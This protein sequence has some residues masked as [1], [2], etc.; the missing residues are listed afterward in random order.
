MMIQQVFCFTLLLFLTDH[1][2]GGKTEEWY[3]ECEAGECGH[4][5]RRGSA[6]CKDSQEQC[7]TFA[8][9]GE[10]KNNPTWMNENCQ[11]SCGLCAISSD[12]DD[13]D[14]APCKD[15]HSSCPT[16]AK[17][18]ECFS[19]PAYMARACPASCWLCVNATAL[20]ENGVNEEDIEHIDKFSQTDFGL[21]QSIPAE[22]KDGQVRD[23]VTNMGKYVQSLK[24][25]GP[26]TLCN[27]LHHDCAAWVIEKGCQ[28]DLEFMLPS[29]SLA[30]Q[31]CDIIEEYHT[32][33]RLT[34]ISKRVPF[35]PFGKLTVIWMNLFHQLNAENLLEDYLED[36]H[37]IDGEYV[38]SLDYSALWGENTDAEREKVVEILKSESAANL[39]WKNATGENYTDVASDVAPDRSGRTAICSAECRSSHPAMDAL[40]KL[41]SKN[42]LQIGD[43][44]LQPLEFVHYKRGERFAAH[45]DFRLHD[46]WKQSGNRVLTVFIALQAPKE[47]GGVGFPELDWLL[48]DNPQVLVW[49]NVLRSKGT[50]QDEALTRMKSE[51]LPVVA[52]E[53]YGVYAWLRQYPYDESSPCA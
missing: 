38:L 47:G 42:L 14:E 53:M 21:W 8:L 17:E 9:R 7:R 39:E 26:G 5:G 40:A 35:W 13:E 27:N 34:S 11:K 33:Q 12:D 31:Y 16:W 10:C 51:Q 48:I 30:C 6:N 46:R 32:C 2:V 43:E 52:G 49:P 3:Q 28:D 1:R 23:E 24:K 29:C 37:E 18:L 19:N 4:S 50:G 45:H 41:I 22:D 20:R 15:L 44:Y 36:E 25:T